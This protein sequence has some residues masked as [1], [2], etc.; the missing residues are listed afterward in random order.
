M[1]RSLTHCL[2]LSDKMIL[3]AALIQDLNSLET[4]KHQTPDLNL[5]HIKYSTCID[6]L[7]SDMDVLIDFSL[8]IATEKC[9]EIFLQKQLGIPYVCGVTGLSE[10]QNN[11]IFE[12]A[13][14]YPVLKASNFSIGANLLFQ[15]TQKTAEILD[16]NW[17]IE[18]LE[19]HHRYKI[20]APS[21]TALAIGQS[22]LKGREKSGKA[23]QQENEDKKSQQTILTNRSK[24]RQIG[25]IGYAALRG[26]SVIGDHQVIFAS[27]DEMLSI[28]H[29][30]LDRSLFAKGALTGAHWLYQQTAGLYTMQNVIGNLF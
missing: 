9:L 13:K 5:D 17:D 18:I 4:I 10:H 27:E 28:Q 16:T 21:G 8:P 7:L 11:L 6:D 15:L 12:L 25:D 1:N 24:D 19:M 26:G 23:R 22:A 20:D 14:S 3:S 30:A 29:R 2:A